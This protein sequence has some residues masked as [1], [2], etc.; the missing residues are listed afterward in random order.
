MKT[1]LRLS[2]SA[3]GAGALLAALMIWGDVSPRAVWLTMRGLPAW[4]FLTALATHFTVYCL[5]ATRFLA[6][7]PP[8]R[9]PGFWPMMAVAASHNLAS[10]V[11]PAKSGEAT[12]VLYLKGVCG[13]PGAVGLA[14][15]VASR[16]YD[17]AVMCTALGAAAL[18]L[19]Q[20]EHWQV[21]RWSAWTFSAAL[22]T[23]GLAFGLLALR[24]ERVMGPLR[25]ALRTLRLDRTRLGRKLYDFSH[26]A[27]EALRQARGGTSVFGLVALTALIWV[28]VFGFYALLARGFGLPERIGPLEAVFGSG[29]AVM[30]NILPL[31]AFA[32]VGTQEAGWVLGFG[33]LGVDRESAFAT[34]LA[35]HLVQ[36]LN[37][38]G[39]GLVG[40]LVLGAL[41]RRAT[42]EAEPS[43][44]VDGG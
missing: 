20:G 31:N 40:H 22:F 11:L 36:L 12:F 41:P 42:G 5:R 4:M 19:S 17:F 32:G 16:L 28:G 37:V 39:M 6:L 2:L 10:Y 27:A 8:Q 7:I 34:G 44:G 9:R 30:S 1:T 38:V 18:W 25:L 33:V 43:G 35:V 24:G 3:L 26:R 21:P 15:L 29:L 14:S 23:A 13:V